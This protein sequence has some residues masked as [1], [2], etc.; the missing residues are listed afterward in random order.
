[1]CGLN[2]SGN[3]HAQKNIYIKRYFWHCY[4][5]IL[6]FNINS[7]HYSLRFWQLSQI[8]FISVECQVWLVY[9]D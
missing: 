3:M 6:E 2:L 4:E 8:I 5:V 7:G 1:M 9:G